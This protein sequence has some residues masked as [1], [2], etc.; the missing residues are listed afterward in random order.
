MLSIED[1][2]PHPLLA[3]WGGVWRQNGSPTRRRL[4]DET[5][6]G[7]IISIAPASHK[8]LERTPSYRIGKA[9]THFSTGAITG[10]DQALHGRRRDPRQ[11]GLLLP[12][13]LKDV[14][15]LSEKV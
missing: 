6:A 3:P 5:R 11:Q 10:G 9:S 12:A 15:A 2:S 8:A 14:T 1:D 13:F 4:S 7:F